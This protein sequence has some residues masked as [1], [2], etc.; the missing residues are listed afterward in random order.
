MLLEDGL[1]VKFK[2]LTAESEALLPVVVARDIQYLKELLKTLHLLSLFIDVLVGLLP[3][4]LLPG[5]TAHHR[6]VHLLLS[7]RSFGRAARL[8]VEYAG[9]LFL[10]HYESI[11]WN[12][13]L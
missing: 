7:K 3:V 4:E 2:H 5:G 12:G 13:L 8:T 9:A 6:L 10:L 11:V 1:Y